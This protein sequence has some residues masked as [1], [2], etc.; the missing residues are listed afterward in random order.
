MAPCTQLVRLWPGQ[1]KSKIITACHNFNE[2][3]RPEVNPSQ[4]V[5]CYPSVYQSGEPSGGEARP[6]GFIVLNRR[7]LAGPTTSALTT[8]G[9][10]SLVMSPPGS[11]S[12]A[13]SLAP[14]QL[15]AHIWCAVTF[16]Y[17]PKVFPDPV[18]V[19]PSRRRSLI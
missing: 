18:P 3:G 10:P 13:P 7:G 17:M 6:R 16:D 1:S 15:S 9:P 8:T 12:S 19:P 11:L 4:V 2:E 5:V 14:S